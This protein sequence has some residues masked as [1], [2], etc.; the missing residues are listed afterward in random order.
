[1]AVNTWDGAADTDWNTAGNWDTTG[2][3]DRV[4]TADDDVVIPNVSNDP[5]MG[6]GLNPEIKSLKIESGGHLTAGANTITIN[7]NN[8]ENHVANNLG[9]FVH[10][11]CT[12]VITGPTDSHTTLKG[13]TSSHPL[14]N[15]TINNSG[16][17]RTTFMEGAIEIEGDLVLTDGTFDTQNQTP[18]DVV[19]DVTLASGTIFNG[20]TTTISHGSLTIA[21]GA[22]Y[23]ATGGT[24]T[25]TT[26][27]SGTNYILDNNGT[28]TH[29]NGTVTVTGEGSLSL[30]TGV[31]PTNKLNNLIINFAG[32]GATALY[33]ALTIEG[34][35]TITDGYYSPQGQGGD[36][37]TT[38]YGNTSVASAG[39]LGDGSDGKMTFHGL[40]TNLGTLTLLQGQTYKFNGGL[41]QLG[42]FTTP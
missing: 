12:I 13:F 42:T 34:A 21:S 22:T 23:S 25:I 16:S 30:N 36:S 32:A 38:V 5:V 31:T 20:G 33:G 29:N 19:G 35:F 4:P 24:T 26:K 40:V 17:N 6:D 37:G 15:L 9:T 28:F 27:H 11:N 3:T 18:L 10:S 8:A 14:N 1:M 2:V 7:D 39:V 41:R